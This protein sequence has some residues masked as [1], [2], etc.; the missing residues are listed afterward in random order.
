M[1]RVAYRREEY[2]GMSVQLDDQYHAER[3]KLCTGQ[4]HYP[5]LIE[6]DVRENDE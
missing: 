1:S 6:P 2:I 3:A 5:W 4:I